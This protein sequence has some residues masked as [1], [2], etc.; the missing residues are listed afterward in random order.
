MVLTAG[1]SII[2]TKGRRVQSYLYPRSYKFPL[3]PNSPASTQKPTHHLTSA[4][5]L[6]NAL[7][8]QPPP[9]HHSLYPPPSS[10]P[11]PPLAKSKQ[12]STPHTTPLPPLAEHPAEP[13]PAR[14][15]KSSTIGNPDV[16]NTSPISIVYR[17]QRW[18]IKTGRVRGWASFREKEGRLTQ[19]SDGNEV[20][21]RM[22]W[23]DQGGVFSLL[24]DGEDS[25]RRRCIRRGRRVKLRSP[26]PTK[27]RIARGS[28]ER[29]AWRALRG[30]LASLD[31]RYCCPSSPS[32]SHASRTPN[33]ALRPYLV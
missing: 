9:T 18:S 28:R 32:T 20:K 1:N 16:T 30:C 29:C 5:C 31:A 13:R 12:R 10:H 23:L 26:R 11:L 6:L 19:V 8:Q 7:L 33:E 3:R 17:E 2:R 22:L 14:R 15:R 25:L 21:M 4:T 27:I 24:S